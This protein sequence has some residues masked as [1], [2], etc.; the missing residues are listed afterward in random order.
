MYKS[1]GE[2]EGKETEE[3]ETRVGYRKQTML[4]KKEVKPYQQRHSTEVQKMHL[5]QN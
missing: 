3:S 5:Q 2:G 1:G 4:K